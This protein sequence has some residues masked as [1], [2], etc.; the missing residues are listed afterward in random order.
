MKRE[1][2]A[3]HK[4][5]KVKFSTPDTPKQPANCQLFFNQSKRTDA[6]RS[7]LINPVPG[8]KNERAEKG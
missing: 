6:G 2:L 8:Q 1:H 3:S 5:V 4:F 7:K